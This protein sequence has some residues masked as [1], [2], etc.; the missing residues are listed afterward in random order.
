MKYKA[1]VLVPILS[2]SLISSAAVL[3]NDINNVHAAVIDNVHDILHITSQQRQ[4]IND[5]FINWL[6]AHADNKFAVSGY[7]FDHARTDNHQVWYAPT[8]DGDILVKNATHQHVNYKIK[9]IGG[10]V[11]YTAKDGT[12]GKCDDIAKDTANGK[13]YSSQQIDTS[14]PVDKYLL[15][16]NGIVYKCKLTGTTAAPDSGFAIKGHNNHHVAKWTILT[17]KNVQ[18]EYRHL[19]KKDTGNDIKTT[20]DYDRITDGQPDYGVINEAQ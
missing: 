8:I 1:A 14:K 13:S 18:K 3:D 10:V 7:Y 17:D 15:A 5:D 2:L 12:T 20:I 6:A 9:A 19:I 16:D 4:Q 11:I